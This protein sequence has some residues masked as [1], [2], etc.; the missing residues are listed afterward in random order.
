MWKPAQL[1]KSLVPEQPMLVVDKSQ[2]LLCR[3]KCR[4]SRVVHQRA[5]PVSTSE[6]GLAG[7]CLEAVEVPFAKMHQLDRGARHRDVFHIAAT[8]TVYAHRTGVCTAGPLEI[9]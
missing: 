4:I 7:V 8:H 2:G 3:G 1:A 5:Q 9:Y 6:E